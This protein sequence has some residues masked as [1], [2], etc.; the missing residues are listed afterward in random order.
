MGESGRE[1]E[2]YVRETVAQMWALARGSVGKDGAE[3][4]V[5]AARRLMEQA[6]D[7]SPSSAPLWLAWAELEARVER[8]DRARVLF[9]EAAKCDPCLTSLWG[10][11][12]AM[13]GRAGRVSSA[14]RMYR[15]AVTLNSSDPITL[16]AWGMLEARNGNFAK[17]HG[18]LE[19]C[20]RLEVRQ[21]R[22]AVYQGS[23]VPSSSFAYNG[24][25]TLAMR[26]SPMDPAKARAILREGTEQFPSDVRLW[27]LWAKLEARERNAD[28]ARTLFRRGLTINPRNTFLLLS[29]AVMETRNGAPRAKSARSLFEQCLA[30]NPQLTAAYVAWGKFEEDHGRLEEAERLYRRGLEVEPDNMYAL[31]RLAGVLVRHGCRLEQARSLLREACERREGLGAQMSAAVWQT[32]GKIEQDL[33]NTPGAGLC[34]AAARRL[35]RLQQQR[36]APREGAQ[37]RTAM[38]EGDGHASANASSVPG[39]ALSISGP[40]PRAIR[41]G[42][43][44]KGRLARDSPTPTE[45]LGMINAHL[46]TLDRMDRQGAGSQAMTPSGLN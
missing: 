28:A 43:G 42:R 46:G 18:L 25:A 31:Q 6:T 19:E 21:M 32:L 8:F 13:E 35:D 22:E 41:K 16:H 4:D 7:G 26:E 17:A 24:L 39:A 20:L 33:G 29:W 23:P 34:F 44:K 1:H 38:L 14:R 12:A 5:G 3:A 45:V 11:Y 30:V 15:R 10:K 40:T 37:G 36:E 2:A 9:E 27:G